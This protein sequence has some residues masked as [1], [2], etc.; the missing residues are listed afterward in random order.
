MS[1]RSYMRLLSRN[2]A[3]LQDVFQMRDNNIFKA[4]CG[5]GG[6]GGDSG[7]AA[8]GALAGGTLAISYFFGRTRV[9]FN[10][11]IENLHV[12]GLVMR[13]HEYFEEEYGSI[14][15]RDVQK[16][17]FGRV[18]DWWNKEEIKTAQKM[19]ADVDKCPQ[20]V[21]NGAAWAAGIIWDELHNKERI[22]RW[23]ITDGSQQ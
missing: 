19:G 20:V 5:F 21:A 7:M 1:D 17:V 18:F 8:C 11:R 9:E 3:A 10:L 15:C 2:L 14:Q 4:C 6:G 16:K 13:L 22:K 12:M 23:R